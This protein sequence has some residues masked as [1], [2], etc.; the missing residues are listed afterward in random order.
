MS[1]TGVGDR[2]SLAALGTLSS[3]RL[4]TSRR[5]AEGD[6]NVTLAHTFATAYATIR[7]D[8][9]DPELAPVALAKACVAVLPIAGAGISIFSG[10][11][12]RLPVGASDD[13]AAQAERLQFTAGE[14]PCLDAHRTARSVVATAPV[15]ARRWPDFHHRLVASTPF[16]SI[17]AF[18]LRGA[19]SGLASVDLFCNG[20]VDVDSLSMQD[21]DAIARLITDRLLADDLFGED[22]ADPGW[23]DGPSAT[24][25]KEVLIAM[26]MLSVAKNLPAEQALAE[27]RMYATQ[28][29]QTVDRVAGAVV[30]RR[31][32]V[33]DLQFDR[34]M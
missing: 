9:T 33:M 34:A 2:F 4:G 26:G 30:S 24:G 13:D 17:L 15:M 11:N 31:L 32:A 5:A 20:T 10:T 25:R 19:L 8:L 18:P 27:L 6:L 28:T 1:A 16:R 12:I 7:S 29:D 3:N 23:L 14:G 22:P 21:V